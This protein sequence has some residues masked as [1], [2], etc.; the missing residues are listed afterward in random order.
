MHK[1]LFAGTVAT[2]VLGWLAV[3]PLS[4][5][6]A[7]VLFFSD[8]ESGPKSGWEGSATKG[9]AVTVWGKGLGTTRGSSY[10]TVNGA[11]LTS[12]AD[13][14]EWG[15]VGPARGLERISFWL[16]ST[17]QDGAGTITV[18]VG[19]ETSNALAFTVMNA[20]IYFISTA[21]GDNGYNGTR[22]AFGG[23]G[24]G[25]WRDIYKFKPTVN[26]S[27]ETEPYIVYVRG[28][29]YTTPDPDPAYSCLVCLRAPAAGSGTAATPKAIV[30]Y[31]GESPVLDVAAL[32]RGAFWVAQYSPYGRASYYTYA[33][34]E[35]RGATAAGDQAIGLWGD[36]NRVVGNH[37]HDLLADAWTG[38]VMVD[39]SQYS[40]LYGNLFQRNGFD[41]YKHNIYVK[42]HLRYI[43]GDKDAQY[44]YIGWNEFADAIAADNHGGVIFVS[45]AGDAAA[46]QYTRYL[47]IH[48]NYFHDGN[49]EFIYTGDNTTLSDIAIYNNVFARGNTGSGP[50]LFLAWDSYNVSVY[51]NTF[52]RIGNPGGP[53]VSVT[54]RAPT[55]ATFKNNIWYA[56]P[57]QPF[58]AVENWLGASASLDH[59]LFFDPDGTT[60]PP[61]GSGI[62]VTNALTGD[63]LFIN[64][65][66]GDFHLQSA[67]PARDAGTGAVAALVTADFDGSPRPMDGVFDIGALEYSGAYVPPPLDTTPPA[68]PTNL[69]VQ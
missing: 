49:M 6:A 25:P 55:T 54:A 12:A 38:V 67:S 39:N 58:L 43:A 66:A 23:G 20:K 68:A 61:A 2:L 65:S 7:P 40:R 21:D 46:D 56:Q 9:A 13:Y 15:A 37:L 35:I 62:A 57:G 63:P 26:P 32:T 10:V 22:A 51:N 52:Y 28:G 45:K 8:L 47:W 16:N 4:A 14:A 17:A 11:A 18:S 36:Q 29:T 19:G 1:P 48:D 33:K 42:T 53:M 5:L 30:G 3:F 60:T 59:D 64:P 41:S 50:G 44:T 34:L 69:T 24:N 31:P 27:G